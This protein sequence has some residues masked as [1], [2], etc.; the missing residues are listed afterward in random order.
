MMCYSDKT[1]LFLVKTCWGYSSILS[2]AE[3]QHRLKGSAKNVVE[4]YK[5]EIKPTEKVE[6]NYF[7]PKNPKQK[8]IKNK[9]LVVLVCKTSTQ[10]VVCSTTTWQSSKAQ[11]VNESQCVHK[12]HLLTVGTAG[13]G[14]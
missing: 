8:S 1:E 11:Y 6:F 9:D 4:I 5:T 12:S 3:V 13:C 10:E 14:M 7:R 2:K